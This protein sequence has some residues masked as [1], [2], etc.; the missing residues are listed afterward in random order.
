MV[1]ASYRG[2]CQWFLKTPEYLDWVASGDTVCDETEGWNQS[3]DEEA[4]SSVDEDE[5]FNEIGISGG[6]EDSDG[7]ED[8]DGSE[9]YESK[10]RALR[11]LWILGKAGSGKSTLMKFLVDHARPETDREDAA[12]SPPDLILTHFFNARGNE[13]EKSSEGMYRTILV[14]MMRDLDYLSGSLSASLRGWMPSAEA[15]WPIPT[16]IKLLGLAVQKLKGRQMILFV[17]A[18]DECNDKEAQAMVHHFEALIAEAALNGQILRVC[19]ASRPYPH[20]S[21]DRAS[22]Y[23]TL[24]SSQEHEVDIKK[25]INSHLRIGKRKDI[26]EKLLSNSKH[27]FLWVK[28]VV[29]MLNKEYVAG[30][31][32]RY[33]KWLD[34]QHGDLNKLYAEMLKRSNGF[35]DDD[36]GDDAQAQLLCFQWVL[37]SIDRLSAQEMWWGI[38]LGLDSDM[39]DVLGRNKKMTKSMFERYIIGISRGLL[40]IDPH[41]GRVHFIHESAREFI[42]SDAGPLKLVGG[43]Q[44]E[45]DMTLRGHL[46]IKKCYES[47]LD[48]C[49]LQMLDEGESLGSKVNGHPLGWYARNHILRHADL[50]QQLQT[51]DHDQG[52]WIVSFYA[53]FKSH[54]DLFWYRESAG[55]LF[56][57]LL[58]QRLL[59]LLQASRTILVNEAREA[60]IGPWAPGVISQGGYT[61]LQYPLRLSNLKPIQTVVEIYLQLETRNHAI[62]QCLQHLANTWTLDDPQRR[63]ELYNVPILNISHSSETLA[64]FFLI[65]LIPADINISEEIVSM[66]WHEVEKGFTTT[67]IFVLKNKLPTKLLGK[68]G[69]WDLYKRLNEWAQEAGSDDLLTTLEAN[70]QAYQIAWAAAFENLE[71]DEDGRLAWR[72]GT[73]LYRLKSFFRNSTLETFS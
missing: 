37:Y 15:S 20:I 19:F 71:S 63:G 70:W 38:Q 52:A 32:E 25:Y 34:G 26:K 13:L 4:W 21:A 43:A 67:L 28:L 62:Q 35:D 69:L 9:N 50:I 61:P 18:L 47:V 6:T 29:G 5:G 46:L 54:L 22:S 51:G 11:L 66:L 30:R 12:D 14:Q 40:E 8:S 58:E 57:I 17:D 10:A 73:T 59:G 31:P 60:R 72:F 48:H 68:T 56:D 7:I 42:L 27:V 53:R 55:P 33:H 36:D 49:A 45:E 24:D 1:E 3:E 39:D 41:L 2:T 23:F 44:N 64:M 65:A 16:L